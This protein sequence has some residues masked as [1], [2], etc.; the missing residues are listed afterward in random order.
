MSDQ[1]L[2]TLSVQKVRDA[3]IAKGAL[4]AA[5]R[6][7]VLPNIAPTASATAVQIPCDVGAIVNSLIFEANGEPVLILTSGAHKVNTALVA[8]HIGVPKLARAHPE[9]VRE[10]TGQAIGSVAPVGHSAPIAT[11]VDESLAQHGEIWAAAGH[12]STVF[13]LSFEELVMVTNPHVIKVN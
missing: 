12:P 5:E 4:M 3:L 11:Y 9:F 10:K 2:Q 1:V 8:Q 7:L 6:I 13:P